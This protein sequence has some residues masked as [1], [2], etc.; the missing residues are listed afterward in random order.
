MKGEEIIGK[1]GIKKTKHYGLLR[2]RI[3][4]EKKEKEKKDKGGEERKKTDDE[5]EKKYNGR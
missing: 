3:K 1:K 2:Q 4:K 5:R